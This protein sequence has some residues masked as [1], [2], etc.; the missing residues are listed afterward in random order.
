[1]KFYKYQ[2]TGN[3]FVIIDDREEKFPLTNTALVA[4]LCDRRFGIGADGLMLLQN[5]PGYDFKM[6]Y[7]NSDGGES[8]MCGNGGRCLARFA[9]YLGIVKNKCSFIAIDGTHEAVIEP[10]V[11]R[12]KMQDVT[13]VEKGNNHYILNTG[14]PHYVC[15]AKQLK[16]LNIIEPAKAVRYNERFADKGINVNFIEQLEDGI[17]VR[18]Y[19]RGVEDETFSCGTGVTA[20]AIANAFITNEL[21]NGAHETSVI[22]PGGKLKVA[23]TYSTANNSF[24]NI[25]LIGPAT[26]VFIGD[27]NY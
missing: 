3:D 8:S 18:T 23:F 25:W 12:L 6:V 22:T 2:G 14:S 21:T 27:V 11:I 7:Y 9:E 15:T 1:M 19:E 24:T 17:F 10:E 16:E 26:L 13:E 4:R 5:A 20:V